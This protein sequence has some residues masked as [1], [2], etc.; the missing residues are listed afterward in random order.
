MDVSGLVRRGK[1][2]ARATVQAANRQRH[3]VRWGNLRRT[4][5]FSAWYGNERGRPV[6]RHYIDGF[7]AAHRAD[8]TGNRVME[9]KNPHYSALYGAPAELAIVDIDPDNPDLTLHAD[10]NKVGSLPPG[11]YDCAIVTQVL[12]YVDPQAALANLWQS[13]APC[14]VLLLTVP[15]LARLDPHDRDSDLYRWTPAGLRAEL[16]AAGLPDDDVRGHGNILAAVCALQGLTVE[17]VTVA[18]LDVVN[19]DFPLTVS[20]RAVKPS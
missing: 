13:L 2:A 7:M 11:A 15:A 1:A 19:Q 14:G 12:Q 20:A 18:E 16:T 3:P 4:S 6:D 9:V 5:P 8:Y 17:D 10:L